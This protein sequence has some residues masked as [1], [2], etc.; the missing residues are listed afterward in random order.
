MNFEN[1]KVSERKQKELL[2]KAEDLVDTVLKY[3]KNYLPF[4]ARFCLVSTFLED[5]VRMWLQ[6]GEQRNYIAETWG[7]GKWFGILFVILNLFGQLLPCG[8]ILAR[9]HVNIAVYVLYGIIVLQTFGYGIFWDFRFLLRNLSLGG[10][11]LLLI[12]ESRPEARSLFAGVPTMDDNKP[13]NIMQFTGRILTIGM[14]LTLIRIDF[15]ISHILL[16]IVGTALI[17]LVAIGYKTKL[18][19]L[20]LVVI[21]AILNVAF[22]P[23]WMID[24]S[25][26]LHDFLKY[27]FFQTLSVIGG[28]LFVV[29]LG[30]GGV[31]L[32]ESKKRW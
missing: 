31:S 20:T 22:N 3:S 6:W 8:L 13:K 24:S 27:D 23:F 29:A 25:K 7:T 5:G 12:V 26:P 28:L 21:L 9:K 4:I 2:N 15:S 17:I 16:N 1:I 14:F 10:G 32:D 19:A 30:P 11:L 18:S